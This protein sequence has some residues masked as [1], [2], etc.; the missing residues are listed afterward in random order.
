MKDRNAQLRASL[1]SIPTVERIKEA[2]LPEYDT[3]NRQGYAAYSLDDEI[4]LIA[5]LNTLK[6]EP[7]FYRSENE[8]MVELRDLIE[9]I[10]L[11]DPYFVAQCIAWS[12]TQGEG[13]RSINH[14]GAALLAPF[15]SGKNWASRFYGPYNK[16]TKSGG[17]I[18]RPD[19]M[20]EIK[21]VFSTLN[22]TTLT[23]AMKKGFA[24]AIESFDSYQLA[25]YKKSIIDISNLVHPN[26]SKAKTGEVLNL[27]MKGET[28]SAD[29]WEVAQ[30]EAGQEVAKAV[31]EGKITKEQA[32]K[33]LSE[34]KNENWK[35]LLK[36]GK[37]G[38]LAALRNISNIIKDGDSETLS[39]LEKLVSNGELIR[40][41]KILPY[42]IDIAHE[43]IVERYPGHTSVLRALEIG[44][45]LSVPNLAEALSGKTCVFVDCSGSMYVNCSDP[46]NL[47]SHFKCT[48]CDKAGL[49]A[50]TIA[51]ATNADIV[52]F[53]S[54][55][56]FFKGSLTQNVFSLGR[57]ISKTNMGGT[58]I[59]K[60][61][62][63]ITEYKK[64]YDRIIII[65]DN[66]CNYGVASH[67]YSNYIRSV[68]SP[69]IYALDLAAYGTI[70]LRN[71][72][73]VNYYFGFGYTFFDDI[74]SKE[75][76]PNS[77]IDKIK[78]YKI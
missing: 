63:L 57:E 34:A 9:K 61:F 41:G 20:S 40:K 12:R 59:A 13:M 38:I 46:K 21:D 74:A 58:N 60:A 47:R 67:S 31:K 71:E 10:G 69:Y 49:I 22:D 72:G 36:D 50:A 53:G 39:M 76:N 44:Y 35:G 65:S 68:C 30:S 19:D 29:T 11:E 5:M 17:C 2:K 25:K 26:S 28:V 23:N 37:L 8:T 1:G 6:L 27:I 48:A 62:Q 54:V 24:K 43:V 33:V 77:V 7:Q 52:R 66:E 56:E 15:A 18:F 42:Q 14:L 51:K 78:A 4:R 70:P 45:E 32:E 55:A 73:K 64:K 3:V 16:A 75:F